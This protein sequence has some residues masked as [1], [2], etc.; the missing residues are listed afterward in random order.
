MWPA[1]GMLC[2]SV[3]FFIRP[4]VKRAPA[5]QPLPPQSGTKKICVSSCGIN[6]LSVAGHVNVVPKTGATQL[7]TSLPSKALCKLLI[8][9]RPFSNEEAIGSR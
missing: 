1:R 9:G 8:S 3:F 2:C 5:E 7:G 4:G 6:R